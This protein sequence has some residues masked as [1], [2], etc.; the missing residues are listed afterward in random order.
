MYPYAYPMRVPDPP[1]GVPWVSPKPPE[2]AG[3]LVTP[4]EPSEQEPV[5]RESTKSGSSGD[6]EAEDYADKVLCEDGVH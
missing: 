3:V 1:P 4:G 5:P 6:R 2:E